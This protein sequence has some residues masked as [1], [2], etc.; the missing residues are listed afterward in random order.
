MNATE[1]SRQQPEEA[2]QK[3]WQLLPTGQSWCREEKRV[4]ILLTAP[5]IPENKSFSL[6]SLHLICP[7]FL[8]SS[9]SHCGERSNPP[10]N[11]HHS[12]RKRTWWTHPGTCRLRKQEHDVFSSKTPSQGILTPHIKIPLVSTQ[13]KHNAPFN[14]RHKI[15][16]TPRL[17]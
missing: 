2:R 14:L 1:S 4:R 16:P 9:I 5:N 7:H 11:S 13:W 8:D 17:F 15:D 6:F 12:L 10:Q 3:R